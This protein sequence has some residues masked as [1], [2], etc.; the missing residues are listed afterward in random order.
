MKSMFNKKLF[1]TLS[2]FISLQ[3]L[4]ET[5]AKVSSPINKIF[6][7]SQEQ[8]P[9]P[10]EL[11]LHNDYETDNDDDCW[12]RIYNEDGSYINLAP[13]A[14]ITTSL[15]PGTT[16]NAT[17]FWKDTK[18]EKTNDLLNKPNFD[19]SETQKEN[20]I[21]TIPDQSNYYQLSALAEI[22]ESN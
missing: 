11:T 13:N 19:D 8:E 2:L 22:I 1:F 12:V 7:F 5:L 20:I 16:Y 4:S 9:T 17:V 18:E 3:P 10:I 15:M 14:E 21:I 6:E